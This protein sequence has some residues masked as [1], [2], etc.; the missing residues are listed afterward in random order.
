MSRCALLPVLLGVIVPSASLAQASRSPDEPRLSQVPEACAYLTEHV[1]SEVLGVE[2]E[3]SAA[4][5]WIP[6]FYSQCIY[7]GVS[8]AP[9]HVRFGFKL[10]PFDL[11]DLGT[12]GG[13]A[14]ELNARLAASG[15]EPAARIDDAGKVSFSYE[16]RDLTMLLMVT[17]IQGPPD[18][19]GRPTE[20][21]AT[22]ELSDPDAT[23]QEKLEELLAF[24]RAQLSGWLSQAVR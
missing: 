6:T 7:T 17:G 15:I 12:L 20:L 23:H 1:A 4:N 16:S 14:V 24:A 18:S 21:V 19:V 2:V 8:D 10:M 13:E 9:K 5:E 11:F 22:Y 3:P